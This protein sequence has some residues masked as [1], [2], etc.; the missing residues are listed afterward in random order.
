MTSWTPPKKEPSF[1]QIAEGLYPKRCLPPSPDIIRFYPCIRLYQCIHPSTSIHSHAFGP[2]IYCKNNYAAETG[3][4][5]Q[6]S[7]EHIAKSTWLSS[8][9]FLKLIWQG[10][11]FYPSFKHHL[12]RQGF[13]WE[14]SKP[15][16]SATYLAE[17]L[18]MSTQTVGAPRILQGHENKMVTS[19]PHRLPRRPRPGFW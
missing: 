15:G 2:R 4:Q 11:F 12:C 9:P 19:C 3:T 17:Q 6:D 8:S 7:S 1:C 13:P 5:T 18:E 10:G 14:Q 16:K